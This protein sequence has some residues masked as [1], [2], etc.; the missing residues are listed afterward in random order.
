LADPSERDRLRQSCRQI[1]LQDY[2]LNQYATRYIT[3][4]K[5]C[6]DAQTNLS[7]IGTLV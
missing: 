3:L 2:P 5:S 4:Y 7:P 6:L 1:A